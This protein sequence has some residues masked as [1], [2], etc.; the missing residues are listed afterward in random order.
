[1]TDTDTPFT[2]TVVMFEP[3]HDQEASQV[4]Q[5]LSDELGSTPATQAMTTE[6]RIDARG[7]PVALVLGQDNA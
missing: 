1:V 2:E 5:D 4:A 7:A 3:G 6:I